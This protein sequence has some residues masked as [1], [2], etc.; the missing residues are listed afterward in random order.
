V[1]EIIKGIVLAKEPGHVIVDVGGLGYGL[2]ISLNTYKA[3]PQI[4]HEISLFVHTYVREDILKLFGFSTEEEREVFEVFITVSGIGPKTGLAILSSIAIDEFAAAILN[5]D[6]ATLTK[7]PGIGK[8][9]AERLVLELKDTMKRFSLGR[10]AAEDSLVE[11]EDQLAQDAVAA[12]IALDCN[13]HIAQNAVAKAY[14]VLGEDCALEDL[15]K[16][17]L[18][19]R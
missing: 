5:R 15:I 7:I 6:I 11:A 4:G 12:L 16:E 2:D 14:A 10:R 3:L 17:S 18:R 9:T 1:I 19:C 8:K 13:P